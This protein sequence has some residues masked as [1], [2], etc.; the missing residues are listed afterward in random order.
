MKNAF[1]LVMHHLNI[2]QHKSLVYH[3][4]L[5][6]AINIFHHTLETMMR[7]YCFDNY[8]DWDESI[9]LSLFAAREFV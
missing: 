6:G 9:P 2:T 1:K 3:P 4:Q 5:Q 8:K 7:N